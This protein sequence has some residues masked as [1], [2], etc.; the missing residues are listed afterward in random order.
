MNKLEF[1]KHLFNNE[2]YI[3]KVVLQSIISIQLDDDTSAGAFK[4]IPGA[5]YVE[6]GQ[7]KTVIKDEVVLIEGD[8]SQPLYLMDDR[9]DFPKDFHPVLKGKG[10]TSTFGLMLFNIVLFYEPLKG[11][12]DY[13][14]K[15]F[16]GKIIEK[17]INDVMVD[18]PEEG[19][20]LPEGKAG[21]KACLRVTENCYF[22]EGLGQLF[23]KPGGLDTLSVDPSILV[24]RDELFEKHKDTLKDPVVFTKIIDEL[25][26]MD[27][28]IQMNG[29]S[30]D[31]YIKDSFISNSRSRMFI[32]FGIEPNTTATGWVPMKKALD[33]GTEEEL[34][35]HYINTSVEGSFSRSMAT[36]KGGSRVKE[37]SRLI[38]R[39]TITE[40]VLDCESPV[41]EKI[42]I[43]SDNSKFWIGSSYIT[44]GKVLK[45]TH[46]N[47]VDLVGSVLEIRVPQY[48][49]VK[50]GNYC[51]TCLG[52]SLGRSGNM[53]TSEITLIPTRFMLNSM[54]G[55]HVSSRHAVLLDLKTSI[56]S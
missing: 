16:T 36:G 1:L 13:V 4:K 33:E 39:A 44:K 10:I 45:V 26:E 29:P 20:E 12:V 27:R 30:K 42:L 14:N 48:C 19:E 52:E 5:V 22:L 50:G 55:M 54:K 43:T 35:V 24:R 49:I 46:E 34:L 56:K 3:E 38:A 18:E 11:L 40:D 7:F 17:I 6:E 47:H 2:L 31:F 25:V 32:A 9:Y 51:Q 37:I 28:K 21:V 53:F 8:V 23:I 41:G 15:V